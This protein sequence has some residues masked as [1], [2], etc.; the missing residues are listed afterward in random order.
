MEH[1]RIRITGVVQG[2]GFRPFVYNLASCLGL[3]G[4]CHN[5]S[6]GVVIE[7]HGSGLEG[8][9]E[10][11][12]TCAPPLAWIESLTVTPAQE[13][14][15]CAGFAIRESVRLEGKSV[16]VSPDISLCGDCLCEMLDPRDRRHLYPFINCT[17]CGPRYTIV[18]DIPYDRPSTTMAPF[19]LCE[20]CEKEYHDP[21]DRRFHAQPNAC[22]ECGPQAWLAR[23]G[24]VAPMDGRRNFEAVR[25]AQG[26]L[27]AGA[28]I[29]IKGIG[30]FHLACDA[31]NGE[32][33]KRL[34]DAKRRPFADDT[35][36]GSNKPFAVMSPSME[37]V[38]RFA[39]A[40]AE[41]K[42]L[43]EGRARPIVLL[44]KRPSTP[45][46]SLVSPN[47]RCFGVMLP[48]TPLHHLLFRDADFTALVMTSGNIADEPITITNEEAAGRLSEI[49][50]YLLLHDRGIYMRAD[51]SI[52]RVRS[53]RPR[54]LRRARGYT[55]EPI[56]LGE[57][58]DEIL[59]C[60][61]ELKNT[62]C[63]TKGRRAIVSTHIGDLKNHAEM[64]FFRETL[65]NLAKTF[66][67]MPVILAHDMHPD[68]LSTRFVRE[69]ARERD[70]PDGR[71][72][73]V[74][75][76]HAHV[77]ACMA[78]HGMEGPVIGIAF[79]GTGLGTDGNIWGGE[80]MTAQMK[81]FT[82][83]AH[84]AYLP[85]PGGDRAARE[86]WRM[87]L[88]YL[89]HAFG[90]EAAHRAPLLF[91]R[92]T[93]KEASVV[94][95]MIRRGI[96]SPLTSSMGRLFDAVSSIAGVRD[97]ITFEAEAAMELEAVAGPDTTGERPYPFETA[98]A[99][100][101]LIDVRPV[102]RAVVRD[103]ARGVGAQ[104]ISK[105]FH[106]TVAE[107]IVS[108]AKGIRSKSGLGVAVLS[109]GVFQNQLLTGLAQ[110]RLAEEGFD[111]YT[112]ERVPAND[113]GISLGQAAVAWARVKEG[114]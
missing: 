37:E 15:A 11:L 8:F 48:Y 7:V 63:I 53:G 93:E 75:H 88:S 62:F 1:A 77:A 20:A 73:A 6:E 83:E 110:A 22:P 114:G 67:S 36:T 72:I 43:L 23:K 41:E 34:R 87:A 65:A 58:M 56:A 103:V 13:D 74:Q 5:D 112:H 10:K 57:E 97:R 108:T 90:D 98:G 32:S 85:L 69:Y 26:L 78:E 2:V 86:P 81:G 104:T 27:K 55:P 92:L 109:G 64:E 71:V 30:G 101:A 4:Y 51:D 12:K 70:I 21:G 59:A 49:A 31:E 29:A 40:N 44:E 99:A 25:Q 60:G 100:P 89:F 52:A 3:T 17:N 106:A 61:G 46:S 45:I 105:R 76:H 107:I 28:I 54:I 91:K 102:I 42:G 95:H 94:A 14:A 47:N 35:S 24:D 68:Y 80:F 84:L 19:R 33:V 16:L 111:V 39:K 96:N 18:K 66:R 113:G 50:D 79:D 38:L 9:V 82:R